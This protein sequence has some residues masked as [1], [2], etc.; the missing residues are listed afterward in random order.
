MHKKFERKP[1]NAPKRRKP[2]AWEARKP[3][4]DKD[5]CFGCSE[6]GHMKKDCP[7]MVST[8]TPNDRLKLLLEGGFVAKASLRI[9]CGNPSLGLMFFQGRINDQ[10]VSML[11]DTR[12]KPLDHE[13][14]K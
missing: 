1:S 3:P 4:K 10:H 11:V 9:E 8:S 6:K 2:K 13:S 14:A 5:A 12:G 7:K